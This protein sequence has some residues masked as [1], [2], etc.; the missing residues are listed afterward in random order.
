MDE[1]A[2]EYDVVVLG[3]G[4]LFTSWPRLTCPSNGD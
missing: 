4:T 2:S 1:I 3:T